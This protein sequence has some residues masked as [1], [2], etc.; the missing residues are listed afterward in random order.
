M[1]IL[2]MILF[3]ISST[4]SHAVTSPEEIKTLARDVY[5]FA[6]P[7]VLMD[8]TR[9]KMTSV[10]DSPAEMA[11]APMNQFAHLRAYPPADAKDVVRPNFDTL[12]STAWLDLSDGPMVLSVPESNGRYY[13]FPILD[14][15]TDVFSSVGTRTI[16]NKAGNFAFV[17]KGWNGTLPEGM[18][19]IEA[20]TNII[21][22]LGR[23][24]ANGPADYENVHKIQNGFKLTPF[25]DWGKNLPPSTAGKM[26]KLTTKA[27][28]LEQVASLTGVEFFT[29]FAELMKKNPPH[30]NDYPI[31]FRME[32]IGLIPGKSWEPKNFDKNAINAINEGAKMGLQDLQIGRAEFGAMKVNG[33][34]ISLD[35]MGT[36]GTSYRQRA[37]I[38]LAGLGANLPADA[39]YPT[40]YVDGNGN[41]LR[42]EEKYVLY[43]KKGEL[44]PANAFW[45]LTMY[46]AE[47]FQVP[48][49]INRF[50]I[51]DRD[52][53]KF[54]KDGSLTLYIQH[55]SPGPEK[56]S[57]WL[58]SPRSGKIAPTLRM[59]APRREVLT[60]KWVPP[61]FQKMSGTLKQAQ[62]SNVQ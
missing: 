12:Y 10:S 6:Y 29:R 20:P 50:A 22:I 18:E 59:Y 53:L 9:Q 52:K 48:N 62:E 47:G 15:W 33:W 49:P 34:N 19:R 5:Q 58:P 38:A 45:S 13:L 41:E 40:A 57:N 39:L 26:E 36:Y 25:K 3:T 1:R 56:E 16:G 11:H 37:I 24:Q 35:N 28:P 2:F 44:P 7:I 46:D 17:P 31:L 43:F 51:G 55:E 32:E 42:G 23:T 61:P 30:S 21:W 4:Q 27:P 14:M 8:I 54:N 60:G